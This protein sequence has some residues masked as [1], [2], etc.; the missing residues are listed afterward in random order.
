[1]GIVR[2]SGDFALPIAK[3]IFARRDTAE[4]ASHR[5][6]YGHVRCP[7]GGDVIDEALLLLMIAPRSYTRE[8]IAEIHCH[9]GQESLRRVLSAAINAGARAAEAGEFTKR[10]FLNGRIDLSKAEAVMDIIGAAS[11]RA[12][13]AANYALEG[14]LSSQINAFYE[15][16]MREVAA[17]EAVLDSPD[18]AY[19]V[20]GDHDFHGLAERIRKIHREIT[21][22]HGTFGYGRVLKEGVNTVIT[23]RPNVGKSSLLN[24]LAG[25]ERSIVTD[26]PGT[27]RDLITEH[28]N[29]GE[30]GIIL[31]LTDTAGLRN[32]ANLDAV[33][34]IGA[35]RAL[36]AARKAELIL[37]VLD[38]AAPL[39]QE[40]Y[41]LA[42]LI[43]QT[44]IPLIC[45]LNKSDIKKIDDK[46]PLLTHLNNPPTAT[47]S[48]KNHQG[49]DNLTKTIETIC[50][51]KIHAT[52]NTI[53]ITNARQ[54]DLLNKAAN[55]LN[56]AILAIETNLPEDLLS[57][58]LMDACAHLAA[59]TGRDASHELIETV[60]A[61]FCMG[62]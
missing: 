59:I 53:I 52:E 55:A 20:V 29:L 27:T 35:Q 22:L 60:F 25:R 48:A 34:H 28:I 30:S 11:G 37:F 21:A 23:G 7:L 46:T 1:M 6:Y 18:H 38:A 51:A 26:I 49:L 33:E 32:S 19:G 31:K 8:D 36:D 14:R 3:K 42:D 58:D 24:A 2:I 40:D 61:E 13:S 9:G 10:A 41:A 47:V 56:S 5:V 50:L 16:L 39:T 54:A 44:A 43:K 12:L 45:I 62:K 17:I 57:V 4:F 15:A